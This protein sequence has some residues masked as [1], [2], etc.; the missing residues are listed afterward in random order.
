MSAPPPELKKKSSSLPRDQSL[1]NISKEKE[2]SL[3]WKHRSVHD[4]MN[5]STTSEEL[6]PVSVSSD[7]KADSTEKLSVNGDKDR[8]N[9]KDA[10]KEDS[11]GNKGETTPPDTEENTGSADDVIMV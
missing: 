8:D 1:P 5:V 3:E 11:N 2:N 6:S 4:P 7:K 10:D 9:S